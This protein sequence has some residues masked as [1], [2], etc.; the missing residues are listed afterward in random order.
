MRMEP[1][2]SQRGPFISVLSAKIAKDFHLKESQT[3]EVN[4]EMFNLLNSSAATSTSY[5][6]STFNR[7][8]GIISPFVGRVGAQFNF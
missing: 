2:G 6:T 4:F 1:F 8:T 3:L 7:V 5:L